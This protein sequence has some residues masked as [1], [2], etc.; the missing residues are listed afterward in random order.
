MDGTEVH[1]SNLSISD[2]FWPPDSR[3]I[4]RVPCAVTSRSHGSISSVLYLCPLTPPDERSHATFIRNH[5]TAD[6]ARA[7]VSA[8][9]PARAPRAPRVSSQLS[10]PAP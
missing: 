8:A 9:E 2:L 4:S 5:V 3:A 7:F 1:Y 6:Q 10:A